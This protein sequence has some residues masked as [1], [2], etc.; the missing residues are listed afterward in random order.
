MYFF[1]KVRIKNNKFVIRKLQDGLKLIVFLLLFDINFLGN[2]KLILIFQV[3]T[4]TLIKIIYNL[5]FV[6]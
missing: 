2:L 3:K 6:T 4:L 5:Y 1:K